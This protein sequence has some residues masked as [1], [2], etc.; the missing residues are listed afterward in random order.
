M[1]LLFPDAINRHANCFDSPEGVDLPSGDLRKMRKNYLYQWGQRLMT[2]KAMTV[3]VFICIFMTNR[4]NK[5][6][7]TGCN[8]TFF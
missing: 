3:T 7:R 5:A 1:L 2:T 4:N 8:E 6:N